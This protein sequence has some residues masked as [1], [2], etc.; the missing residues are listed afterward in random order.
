[1]TEEERE[2]QEIEFSDYHDGS[3]PPDKRAAFERRLA[4]DET[5][6]RDYEKFTEALR[7]LSGL[8]K[9]SAPDKLED[10]VADTIYRRSAGRFF[11]PRTLGDRVPLTAIAVVGLVLALVVVLLLRWSFTGPIHDAIPRSSGPDA[12]VGAKDVMPRP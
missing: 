11:G 8:H 1:M 5:F 6:R 3:M 10:K 4:S 7:A 12:G 2:A 9:M